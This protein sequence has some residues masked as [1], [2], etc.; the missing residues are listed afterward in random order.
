L[1][2][3]IYTASHPSGGAKGGGEGRGVSRRSL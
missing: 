1:Q 2:F 3:F